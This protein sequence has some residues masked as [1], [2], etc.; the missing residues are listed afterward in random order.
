MTPEQQLAMKAARNLLAM[1]LLKWVVIFLLGWW[2]RRLARK[3]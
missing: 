3:A 1:L 2:A